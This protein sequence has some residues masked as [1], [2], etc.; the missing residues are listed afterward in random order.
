MRRLADLPDRYPIRA[1]LIALVGMLVLLLIGTWLIDAAWAWTHRHED[2]RY[3][4]LPGSCY[5]SGDARNYMR[6]ALDGYSNYTPWLGNFHFTYLNDRSWWPLFPCVTSLV[7]D[8]GGGPCSSRAVNGIA[9][10]ALVPIFQALTGERRWW[11]LLTLA[12]LPYGA[13]LYVGEA[14]TFLLALSGVLVWVA[15]PHFTP[16][17]LS[18]YGEREDGDQV[19]IGILDRRGRSQTCPGR[20]T[21]PPLQSPYA[22]AK[23]QY[24]TVRAIAAFVFGILI[25]LAKP[26]GLVLVPALG[27]WGLVLTRDHLRAATR[28]RWRRALGDTNPGW[29]PVLGALGIVLATAWWFFQISGFYPYYVLLLQR[30]LWWR[31]FAEWDPASFAYVFH[32]AISYARHGLLNLNELAR[33]VELSSLV[34]GLALGLSHLPPRWPG[35]ERIALPLHWRVGILGTFVLMFASG[36]SHAVERYAASN[37]FIVLAWHRLVFGVPGQRVTWRVTTFPGLLRWVWLLLGPVLW[38]LSFTLLGWGVVA[39]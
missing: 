9:F 8:L 31:E 24:N 37:V 22:P 20:V 39:R 10:L 38:G 7:I 34:F 15:R 18:V 35:G 26:N 12:V 21:D 6:I 13:W 17:P 30:T 27:L 32:K 1:V 16:G 29:G 19:E 25:G 14:D 4:D 33:L 5:W 36:Q 28:S 2:P 3:V 11:V 23:A